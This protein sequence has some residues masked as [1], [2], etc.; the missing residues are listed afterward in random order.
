MINEKLIEYYQNGECVEKDRLS[1]D[2]CNNIEYTTT[3]YLLNKYLP[4]SGSV[5]DCCA[6]GGIY[7]FSL[8]NQ[9]YEVTAGDLVKKHVDI[10]NSENKNG[11]LKSVYQGDVLDMSRFSNESFDVVLCMGALYHLMELNDR[12]KCVEGCLRVLKKGGL[13]VAAYINRNAVYI[14]H[15]NQNS[16]V[17]RRKH[18]L[19]TGENG[20][21]YVM[22]FGE[23]VKLLIE[24]PLETITNAGVDG[25]RYPLAYRINTAENDDFE[26][27]MEYHLSSCEEP[28][29]IGHSMHGL[30][31][32]RK[33]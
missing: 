6:G 32:G 23:I 18:I 11:L 30:Y 24:F 25:L 3:M 4:K 31:I 22:D 16:P 1:R 12:K 19:E 13:F 5:L 7:A 33:L 29:I 15:F 8:A 20:M 10:L 21:F 2:R 14:N 27:Y 28:S 17:E 26:N 9:G